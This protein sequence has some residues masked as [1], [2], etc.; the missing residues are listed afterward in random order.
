MLSV[1]AIPSAIQT[2]LN[3]PPGELPH[4]WLKH[5]VWR[6]ANS[7]MLGG[8]ISWPLEQS[9]VRVEQL[10]MPLHNLGRPFDG[11]R[12]VHLSDLHCGMLVREKHL[13]RHVEIVNALDAD[14]VAITG[15]FITTGSRRYARTVAKVL[16]DVKA[17]RGVVACLGNHDYGRW[18]PKGWGEVKGIADYLSER[19]TNAGISVL[20]NASRKFVV[21]EAMLQ[22]VG[23]EDYW[24]GQY[25]AEVA[26]EKVDCEHPV[27]A[28]AHNPDA[29]PQLAAMGAEWILSGHTHGKA[30]P[31][32]RFWDIVYPTRYKQ[33]I[34][35]RYA[36]GRGSLLYVNRG[37][38]NAWRV[39]A[40][41][42]P[43]ITLFSLRNATQGQRSLLAPARQTGDRGA[44]SVRL[45]H[46]LHQLE[47]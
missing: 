11:A 20:R 39:R 27:I 4:R 16:G 28:L 14:F 21:G 1:N 42:L 30:T 43:E 18:H 24:S 35:G 44:H 17:A 29:A 15:D 22:F 13:R 31:D 32:T 7:C 2:P 47:A 6:A 38:G 12:L 10:S 8:L 33:F 36:L 34:G 37:I 26:F 3:T 40:M 25:D 23:L 46:R 45:P 5:A 19:L 41:H 9:W